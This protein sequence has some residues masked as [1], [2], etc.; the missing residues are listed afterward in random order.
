MLTRPVDI[1]RR[2]GPV[3]PET[4][5]S[6]AGMPPAFEHAL[7]ADG[8]REGQVRE[9]PERA[10]RT[11]VDAGLLGDRRVDGALELERRGAE[12]VGERH[13]ERLARARAGEVAEHDR[14]V[15]RPVQPSAGGA[16]D[17]GSSIAAARPRR[18]RCRRSSRRA[19]SCA[20]SRARRTRAPAP[21]ARPSRTV[22]PPSPSRR[23]R[24]ARGSRS[25]AALV[26][27]GRCATTV[28]SERSPS[29]VW[30]CEA[31]GVHREAAAGRAAEPFELAAP[32]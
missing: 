15:E 11:R 32:T 24:G 9:L 10:R 23:R 5:T 21:A 7:F 18:R 28:L 27:P 8:Q 29:I 22:P 6:T 1:R 31:V 14:R 2:A 30:A 3:R 25:A 4:C 16:A 17:R 12:A 20:W 13:D 19:R 26:E